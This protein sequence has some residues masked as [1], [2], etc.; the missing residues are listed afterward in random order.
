[1]SEKNAFSKLDN[2]IID[3]LNNLKDVVPEYIGIVNKKGDFLYSNPQKSEIQKYLIDHRL[4]KRMVAV[5]LSKFGS[6]ELKKTLNREL[7]K[8][9]THVSLDLKKRLITKILPFELAKLQ[10]IKRNIIKMVE[11]FKGR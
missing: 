6:P 8:P 2:R 11:E 7:L 1:M 9:G 4:N 3:Y 10:E 5:F